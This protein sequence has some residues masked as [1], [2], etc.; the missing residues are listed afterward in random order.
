ME[1]D[2]TKD[3]DTQSEDGSSTDQNAGNEESAIPYYRF[4]EINDKYKDTKSELQTLKEEIATLKPKEEEK[5]PETWR[6]VEE[7][8]AKKAI[9]AIESKLNAERQQQSEAE[10]VIEK[11]FDQLKAL[12]QK[13]TPEIRKSVLEE[14]VKTGNSVHEAFINVKTRTDKKDTSDQIKVEGQLP[15][16]K[17]N[18]DNK[19]SIPYKDIHRL[20]TDQ[21]IARIQNRK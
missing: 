10:Q 20:S 16:S 3:A 13:I 11:G 18:E 17:G 2:E 6:E 21:L 12:G 8:A 1:N 15:T 7:R 14:I 19:I 4:K 9:S 5:E